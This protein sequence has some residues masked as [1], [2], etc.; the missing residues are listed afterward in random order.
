MTRAPVTKALIP[1]G[2]KGTR[3]S[4]LTGGA[5]KELLPIGGVPL[6]LRVME[7]CAASGISEVLVV[8]APGKSD[9]DDEVLSAAGSFGMP[10]KV[11]VVIQEEAR[12]VRQ[13]TSV[14]IRL[15]FGSRGDAVQLTLVERDGTSWSAE[16]RGDTAWTERTIRLADFASAKSAM[17]PEGF[18]GE[19]NYWVSAPTG[20]GGM[21]DRIRPAEIERVQLSLRPS[22][23]R[24]PKV[25]I[26]WVMLGFP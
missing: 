12:A 16:V 8:S 24:D 2:G 14:R 6:V 17:L 5:A 1:C 15:R 23:A 21:E 25:E 10:A 4:T 7:E 3:M 9:L 20:R 18:P 26:E 22:G 19:W 11:D 13:A